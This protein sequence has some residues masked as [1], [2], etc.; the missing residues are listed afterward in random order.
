[1][2]RILFAF[3][4]MLA[5]AG[6]AHGADPRE[7]DIELYRSIAEQVAEGRPYHEA[8]VETQREVGYPLRP[9]YTVR[10]PTLAWLDA[11]LGP[12]GMTFLAY[13]LLLATLFAWHRSLA[14]APLRV[15]L[16]FLG[17]LAFGGAIFT[18]N[19][20]WFMHDVVAG[21]LVTLALGLGWARRL[22]L[23]VAFLAVM[24]RELA[25]PILGVLLLWN[26]RSPWHW[27]ALV[28]AAALIGLHGY[29]VSALTTPADR[30]SIAWDGVRGPLGFVDDLQLLIP[31]LP[32]G[33]ALALAIL[34]LAGWLRTRGEA[35]V[36]ILGILVLLSVFA[37]PDNY[38]WAALLL[39]LHFSGFAFLLAPWNGGGLRWE[40]GRKI[41]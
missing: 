6:P 38:Y 13:G 2:K 40:K 19:E 39:P 41:Q 11:W 34:P 16:V 26:W 36:W 28:A 29:T 17:S 10:M 33:A 15:R 7:M 12:T 30:H 5:L 21:F 8:A 1:M 3:V 24:V 37:R 35:L 4:L 31:M 22:Q 25:I 27:A 9:F 18:G 23:L 20:V 14:G 32:R